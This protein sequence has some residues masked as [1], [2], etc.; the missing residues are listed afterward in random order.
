MS[1][2]IAM[3]ASEVAPFA[4]TGGLADVAGALCKYLH[5]AGHDIRLFMPFYARIERQGLDATPVEFL[6]DVPLEFGG[7][8]YRYSVYSAAVPGSDARLY[9]IDCSVLYGRSGIYTADVDEHLRFL[10]LTRAS[11]EC[12]QRMGW[13]PQIFHCNDWHTAFAPLL[14]KSAYSWDRLFAATRSVMTIHNIG[15]QGVFAASLAADLALGEQAY[16]LHQDDLAQG[17]INSLRHGIMYGDVVTTVSPTYAREILTPE[18]GMGLQDDL[19]ARARQGQLSG[20]LNGVDYEEWD[21]RRDRWLPRHFGSHQIEVKASLKAELLERLKLRGGATAML[22]GL[23]S[24]FTAQKGLDLLFDTLPP[25]LA[26][27][28]IRFV[29][30]GSGEERY[31]KFFQHLQ[32]QFPQQVVYHRGYSEEMAHWIEAASDAFIMPSL[33][34]PCGLNQMY[35]LRYGTIPI[36]RRTGGLADSV[37]LFDPATGEG[38]GIVFDDFNTTAMSW[39]LRAAIDLYRQQQLWRGLVANAMAQDFSW[40][41]QGQQYVELYR[42]L[43]AAP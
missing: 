23:V 25:L 29:A 22:F 42:R 11:I 40:T 8:R 18:F 1:L 3:V 19:A 35:S 20:I 41:R 2:R 33:Y 9:L 28:N 21:P 39:A 13:A 37:Q 31:E 34:E 5:G 27:R 38:T 43:L 24:R 4:K 32:Q 36:V 10:A 17:R 26:S 14:L 30:T 15:Y 6:Q 16:L 7:H 12:C